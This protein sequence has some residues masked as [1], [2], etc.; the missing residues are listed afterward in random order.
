MIWIMSNIVQCDKCGNIMF[1]THASNLDGRETTLYRCP[2]CGYN[3]ST[4]FR[5]N[6]LTEKYVKFVKM[7]WK[8]Q[9]KIKDLD[10]Q[11]LPD[12]DCSNFQAPYAW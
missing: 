3:Y 12:N 6:K 2:M 8:S 4:G 9:K 7:P 10:S 11:R 5:F 1:G